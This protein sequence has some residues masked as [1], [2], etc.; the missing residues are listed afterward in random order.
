MPAILATPMLQSLQL[1]LKML[2]CL[3]PFTLFLPNKLL[4]AIQQAQVAQ[5]APPKM[6][7]IICSLTSNALFLP[8]LIQVPHLELKELLVVQV[9]A[10]VLI[11]K[12]Y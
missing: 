9:P 1:K 10:Q 8:T 2:S 6:H 12:T 4:T 11:Q 5:V 7:W 3:E